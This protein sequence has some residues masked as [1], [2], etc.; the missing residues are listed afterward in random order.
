MTDIA[1]LRQDDAVFRDIIG[2][3][4]HK[5]AVMALA[6]NLTDPRE[7]GVKKA[8][9]RVKRAIKRALTPPGG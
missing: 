9:A 2:Y 1:R 8:V 5:I 3:R 6:A 7:A 4:G